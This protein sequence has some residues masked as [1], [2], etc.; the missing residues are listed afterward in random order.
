MNLLQIPIIDDFWVQPTDP[1]SHTRSTDF[2][3]QLGYG[4]GFQAAQAS[5]EV[6]A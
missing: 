2:A 1:A 4:F 3:V 6:T 5:Q